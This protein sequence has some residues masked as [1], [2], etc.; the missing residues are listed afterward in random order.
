MNGKV[1][2][3]VPS[4]RR[5]SPTSIKLTIRTG[6]SA[7]ICHYSPHIGGSV[8]RKHMITKENW[9]TPNAADIFMNKGC[10]SHD[11]PGSC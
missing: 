3:I 9:T 1:S 6:R 11:N 10:P 5:G 2:M 7:F 4:V 8:R